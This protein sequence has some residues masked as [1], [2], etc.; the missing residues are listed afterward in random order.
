MKKIVFVMP[1]F[2]L[3]VDASEGGAIEQLVNVLITKN[4]EYKKYKFIF[5]SPK[6]VEK[7]YIN[8]EVVAIKTNKFKNFMIRVLNYALRKLKIKIKF[9][10]EYDKKTLKLISKTKFDKLIFEGT[11][12][13]NIKKYNFVDKKDKYLHVHHQYL[14]KENI[15]NY[16]GNL[17]SVSDFIS[18]DWKNNT[19]IK[20]VDNFWVLLNCLTSD[21]F[22]KKIDLKEKMDIRKEYGFSEDDFLVM[23]CGRIVEEKGVRELIKAIKSIDNDKIKLL[24]AG[25]S[26]FKNSKKTEFVKEIEKL[27]EEIKERIAFT[28]FV[29]NSKLY[30]IYNIADLQVI[31]SLWEEAAGLVA[32]EGRACK[33]KQIIT[34]S[35]GL[36]EYASK[37]SVIIDKSGNLIDDLKK[38]IN[39]IYKGKE[40]KIEKDEDLEK[41]FGMDAYYKNF[42]HIMEVQ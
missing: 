10:N 19:N 36:P 9:Y 24:I 31:P 17:I 6:K 41:K 28:G 5:L 13:E 29:P 12:P 14:T 21:N 37:D 4:E 15:G 35:G 3:P 8:T 2:S 1:S 25:E 38:E 27:S 26:N 20:N 32:L 22:C 33:V 11:Y 30:R 40:T 23:F 16:F 34:N 7:K 42:G 39:K 18:N